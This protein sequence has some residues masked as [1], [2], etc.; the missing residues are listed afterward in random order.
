MT[1]LKTVTRSDT[2]LSRA[3]EIYLDNVGKDNMR[4]NCLKAFQDEL[5]QAKT[6]AATYFNLCVQKIEQAQQLDQ[7]LW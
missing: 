2:K 1:N 3:L 4:Q 6:T 7:L 5:G